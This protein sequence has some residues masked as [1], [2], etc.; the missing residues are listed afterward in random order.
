MPKGA[1]GSVLS[2]NLAQSATCNRRHFNCA[3]THFPPTHLLL[4]AHLAL[5][6]ALAHFGRVALDLALRPRLACPLCARLLR[7]IRPLRT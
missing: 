5:H 7:V 1:A 2:T 4:A 3:P 6:K